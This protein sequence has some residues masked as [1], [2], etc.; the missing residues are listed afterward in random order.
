MAETNIEWCT[1][2]WNPVSGCTRAGPECDHCYAVVQTHIRGSNPSPIMQRKYAGL[3]VLNG[4]GDR[5]FNGRVRTHADT[6]TIPLER[7]KPARFFVNSMS[8]LFHRDVPTEFIDRVM[9]SMMIAKQHTYYVLTKR[10]DRLLLWA[11]QA[12]DRICHDDEFPIDIGG[13][14]LGHHLGTMA[15]MLLDGKW[16]W[17]KGRRLRK[18]IEHFISDGAGQLDGYI[19]D[20]GEDS[21][22]EPKPLIWP[23]RNV[24]LGV[25]VGHNETASK[26]L[27][28][29]GKLKALGWRTM[30]SYEPAI[31]PVDWER[32]GLDD[33]GFLVMDWLISGGESGSGPNIRPTLPDWHRYARDFCQRHGVPFFFKQWGEY[34]TG[35]DGLRQSSWDHVINRGVC[36]CGSEHDMFTAAAGTHRMKDHCNLPAKSMYRVGRKAAGRLLDGREWNELPKDGPC[37]NSPTS[38]ASEQDCRT[39]SASDAGSSSAGG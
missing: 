11:K 15:G 25:S 32:F 7:R 26:R 35:A 23:P 24:F 38:G 28:V 19:E 18:S 8:D 37:T 21:G 2:V 16:V 4:Q 14:D 20:D 31:G 27:P 33:D 9:T 29:L 22:Y 17:E 30:V 6:L 34:H 39:G 10:E 36:L 3:T 1:D 5:H 12:A 13:D